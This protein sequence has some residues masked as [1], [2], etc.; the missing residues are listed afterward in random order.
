[1]TQLVAEICQINHVKTND[2][3]QFMTYIPGK[4]CFGAN[5]VAKMYKL[6]R[7]YMKI[8]QK[9]EP[10]LYRITIEDKPTEYFIDNKVMLNNNWIYPNDILEYGFEFKFGTFRSIYVD[11]CKEFE[12]I[13]PEYELIGYNVNSMENG[14]EF[15]TNSMKIEQNISMN[16][17]KFDSNSMKN[18]MNSMQNDSNGSELDQY[19]YNADSDT[20]ENYPITQKI[21]TYTSEDSIEIDSITSENDS[22][23]AE[24][25]E[26][27]KQYLYDD[28][29]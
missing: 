5:Y 6:T 27:L 26:E 15:D 22:N 16:N 4:V 12:W 7:D 17:M 25:D 24:I 2:F 3:D 10:K 8:L 9:I 20:S 29:E 19:L 21:D 11:E 14:L 28:L 1:M 18:D 13:E 23:N